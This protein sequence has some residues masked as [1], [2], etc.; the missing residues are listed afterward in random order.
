MDKTARKEW[1][2]RELKGIGSVQQNR[3]PL[4]APELNK[5]FVGRKI[6]YLCELWDLNDNS[7]G[8]HWSSGLIGEISDGTWGKTMRTIWKK[9]EAVKVHWDAIKE[10]DIKSV[11]LLWSSSRGCGIRIVSMHGVM[12]LGLLIMVFS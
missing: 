1:R 12:T 3:Q 9:D 6:E 10:A 5:T 7:L 11:V 4:S 8:L 2:Y